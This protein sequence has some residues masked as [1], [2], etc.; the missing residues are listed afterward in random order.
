MAQLIFLPS[1][2]QALLVSEVVGALVAAACFRVSHRQE[3]LSLRKQ[4]EKRV[5]FHRKSCG[6][7]L[8]GEISGFF[9][10]NPSSRRFNS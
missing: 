7:N 10:G 9:L 5:F 1:F 6:G 4:K 2:A 3:F 8:F